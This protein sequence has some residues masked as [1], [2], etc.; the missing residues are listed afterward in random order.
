MKQIKYTS[1][2]VSYNSSEVIPFLLADLFSINPT[3]PVIIIDN[4][5]TDQTVEIIKQQFPQALL[6][7]NTENLGYAKAVNQGFEFCDTPYVFVLNP[8]IRIPSASVITALVDY[9]DL[10]A[11]YWIYRSSSIYYR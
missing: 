7:Q 3:G 6:I 5:S 10:I 1:L 11:P 8:D 2:I 4:A 9:L